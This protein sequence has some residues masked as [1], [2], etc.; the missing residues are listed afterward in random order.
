MRTFKV[1]S[2]VV[3]VA[4]LGAGVSLED[5][6]KELTPGQSTTPP[7]VKEENPAVK[8]QEPNIDVPIECED[9]L[10]AAL[11]GKFIRTMSGGECDKFQLSQREQ[12]AHRIQGNLYGEFGKGFGDY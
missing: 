4:F 5:Q 8:N 12:E 9:G 2:F 1:L 7:M 10:M 3:C 11:I 6:G